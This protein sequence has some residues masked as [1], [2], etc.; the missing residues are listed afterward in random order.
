[1]IYGKSVGA[2]PEFDE[3]DAALVKEREALFNTLAGPR[4]GDY[5]IFA[6]GV[7]RRISHVWDWGNP[8][9]VSVQTSGGGSWH[10]GETGH[11][12]FSGSLHQ[13][14]KATTL[15]LTD[16]ARAGL[17]WIFHHGYMQAHNAVD[18]NIEFRVYRST[19]KAP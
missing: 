7:T 15:T 12:S 16:E 6:D 8:D 18:A 4:V 14:V 9:E 19:E 11:V 10:L 1:M 3:R 5:V 2:R 17:V 13:G